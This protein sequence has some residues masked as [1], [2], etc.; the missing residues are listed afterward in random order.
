[1]HVCRDILDGENKM[2]VASM[3]NCRITSSIRREDVVSSDT[4][5]MHR[6]VKN[7]PIAFVFAKRLQIDPFRI[8]DSIDYIFVH[9]NLFAYIAGLGY[10]HA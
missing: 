4:A 3:I 8:V 9:R 6:T 2:G 1:M 10:S 7:I 5:R